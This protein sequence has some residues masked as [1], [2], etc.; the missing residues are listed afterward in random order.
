MKKNKGLT[1]VELLVTILFIGIIVTFVLSISLKSTSR[2][3]LRGAAREITA[4]IYRI[5]AEA[6]KEN[7]AIRMTFYADTYEYRYWDS[8]QWQEFKTDPFLKDPAEKR[9][10]KEVSISTPPDFA[11]NPRGFVVYPVGTNQF[12]LAGIQT[13]Q[14][15]SPGSKGTDTITIQLSPVGG[16]SVKHKFK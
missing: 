3:K 11:I 8:T 9:L 5:K 10:P 7:R 4:G 1:V 14:L 2:V 16:I 15:Q 6:A 13:I 12:K